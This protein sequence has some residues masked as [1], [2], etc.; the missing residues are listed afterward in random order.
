MT[1][2]K[3][4]IA[5]IS[6]IL[7]QSCATVK[8]ANAW[9]ADQEDVNEFKKRNILV[10]AR[11]NNE[12]SRIAFEMEIADQLRAK[13]FKAIESYT[14]APQLNKPEMTEE[15]IALIRELMGYEGFDG[16]VI[17]VVKDKEQITTKGYNGVYMGASYSNY[18]P[19][20]YGNFYNYYAQ[21]YAYGSYYNSFGGYITGSTY[22]R[23]NTKYVLETIAYNLNESDEDQLIAVVTTNLDDPKD[24]FKTAKKYVDEMVK[25]LE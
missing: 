11:T 19:G 13:G 21:P 3:S 8:V 16:V 18:Y 1:V 23:T 14:K 7:L 12:Q 9:K 4:L 17:T 24:A 15:R 6:L 2:N 5:I 20:Y 22:T 10:I 25:A